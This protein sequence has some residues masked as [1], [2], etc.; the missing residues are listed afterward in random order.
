MTA[1]YW[2]RGVEQALKERELRAVKAEADSCNKQLTDIINLVGAAV[3][4][5]SASGQCSGWHV[6]SLWQVQRL[7]HHQPLAGRSGPRADG[8]SVCPSVP[9]GGS[10]PVFYP[11]F[12]PVAGKE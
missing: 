1:V 5:Q 12:P 8:V 2:T 11:C 9:P 7:S 10:A 3:D 6:I 4:T